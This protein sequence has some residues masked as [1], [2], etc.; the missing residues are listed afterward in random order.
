[1]DSA[2]TDLRRPDLPVY[3]AD[4]VG[5]AVAAERADNPSARTLSHRLDAFRIAHERL[6]RGG[7]RLRIASRRENP[8]VPVRDDHLRRAG[9]R[10]DYGLARRHRL[11]H[12]ESEALDA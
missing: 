2:L 4:L 10:R 8:V 5:L 1:M 11:E 9:P 12:G 3:V 7:E 6:E